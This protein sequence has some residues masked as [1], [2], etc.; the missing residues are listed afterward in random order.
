MSE[1]EPTITDVANYYDSYTKRQKAVGI[2]IRHYTIMHL[3]KKH[4]L[5]P[6]HD[7]LEVGAGIGTFSTL[8]L[9]H[10]RR[11]RVVVSDISPQSIE[12]AKER[13]SK[14]H[15]N[16]EFVVATMD[17]LNDQHLFDFVILPDVLEH[18]PIQTHDGL[19]RAIR[20]KMKTTGRLAI[21]FPH[22]RRIDFLRRHAP[23][24]LQ[25]VDQPIEA[26]TLLKNCYDAGLVLEQF[27]SYSLFNTPTDAQFVLF[28]TSDEPN[29]FSKKSPNMNRL[30]KLWL[31]CFG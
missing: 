20:S 27:Q 10:V 8:L 24:K 22:P 18:I 11:G 30:R 17:S 3:V 5:Q 14:K 12:I 7:V 4:G 29:T 16:A 28:K 9:K 31:M 13:L 21:N 23:E 26:D 15:P 2:N 25:I 19:F 1:T 6:H